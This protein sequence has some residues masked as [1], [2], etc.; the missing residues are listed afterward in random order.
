ME[1]DSNHNVGGI[2]LHGFTLPAA[3]GV[4]WFAGALIMIAQTLIMD[5]IMKHKEKKQK[6]AKKGKKY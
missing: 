5:A 6:E 1:L 2:L 3:M 4:Y